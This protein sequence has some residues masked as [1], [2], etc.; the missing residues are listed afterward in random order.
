[1][2]KGGQAS[3]NPFAQFGLKKDFVGSWEDK[4][5]YFEKKSDNYCDVE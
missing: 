3:D 5:D 2:K 4:M 1:M